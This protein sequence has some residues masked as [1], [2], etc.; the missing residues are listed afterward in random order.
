LRWYRRSRA[1][2]DTEW[3]SNLPIDHEVASNETPVSGRFHRRYVR[4]RM[5]IYHHDGGHPCNA[6]GGR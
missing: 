1:S 2:E 4:Q 6:G 3:K 5:R